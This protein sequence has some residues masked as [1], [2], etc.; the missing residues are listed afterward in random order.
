M[1]I[2]KK[3][4]DIKFS[5][6]MTTEYDWF[7]LL[8]EKNNKLV[9]TNNAPIQGLSNGQGLEHSWIWNTDNDCKRVYSMYA[10]IYKLIS[11][12]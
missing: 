12:L 9:N 11:K 2:L 6:M 4:D 8:N 7:T 1:N 3:I 10:C 5:S